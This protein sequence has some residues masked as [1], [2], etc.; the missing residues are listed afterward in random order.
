MG[1]GICY[2]LNILVVEL[3]RHLGVP[4]LVA[5]CWVLEDGAADRPDHLIALALLDS[6]DGP[7]LVP[8]EASTG[9]QGARHP[10]GARRSPHQGTATWGLNQ[11]PGIPSVPG[12]W[13]GAQVAN[14]PE[15][16]SLDQ[17]L[18]AMRGAEHQ[19]L[20]VER[21]LLLRAITLVSTIEGK[22]PVTQIDG[23]PV[24]TEEMPFEERIERLRQVATEQLR[25]EELVESLLAVM[26]GEYSD[27]LPRLDELLLEL[28]RR[29]LIQVRQAP[30]HQLWP[31]DQKGPFG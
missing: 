12:L 1:R 13:S 22:A 9:P 10:L 7:C 15:E 5:T 25:R 28:I 21:R 18:E 26:R 24:E 2:E 3:L 19:R 6:S 4:A 17:R 11:R 16:A 31:A 8:L 14:L 20:L 23:M 27:G 29:G 30:T